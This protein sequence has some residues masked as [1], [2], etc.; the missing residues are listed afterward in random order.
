[1]SRTLAMLTGVL[2]GS[3]GSGACLPSPRLVIPQSGSL[4][5]RDQ[6]LS[7]LSLLGLF[8]SLLEGGDATELG[9]GGRLQGGVGGG[10]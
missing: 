3:R 5:V 4:P 2:A 8:N 6:S 7:A 9:R 10:V 1:M